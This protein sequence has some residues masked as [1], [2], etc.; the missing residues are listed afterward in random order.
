VKE[1]ERTPKP[2]PQVVADYIRDLIIHDRLKPGER[3]RERQIAETLDVSRT[4]LR[5]AL[6]I[7]ALE[8]LVEL[9][10]NKGAAVVKPS[11]AEIEH[12][13][14]VYTDLESLGGRLAARMATQADIM[15][16]QH[17]HDLLG[18]AFE[19]EDRAAYF[20][21]NQA[22]HLSI[23]TASRNPILTEMHSHLNIRLY[24][25]RYLAV[26]RM[27]EWTAAAGEHEEIVTALEQRDG[28]RLAYLLKEHLGFAWRLI[29]SWAPAGPPSG[30]KGLTRPSPIIEEREVV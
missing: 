20:A 27:Q 25:I 30:P 21:A 29:G 16:V 7:L 1:A 19:A 28:E 10:P 24:R 6:K 12:M 13:L 15:R 26:M 17:Y 9:T 22:F 2:L 18:K 14:T 23:I 8:R 11:D 5:D 3:I 4:P